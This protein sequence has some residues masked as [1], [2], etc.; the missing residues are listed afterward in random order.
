MFISILHAYISMEGAF[1][2]VSVMLDSGVNPETV[3]ER[4]DRLLARYGGLGAYPREDQLSHRF[5]SEELHGLETMAAVFPVI[6]LGVA[7]S[8][9]GS[10]N[11]STPSVRSASILD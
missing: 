8:T 6:F 7:A 5:L 10:V 3:I 4:L 1:N 11:L 2:N 9:F